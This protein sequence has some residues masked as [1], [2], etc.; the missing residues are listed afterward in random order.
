[1]S[2]L[3]ATPAIIQHVCAPIIYSSEHLLKTPL[4]DTARV[5]M[6]QVTGTDD[7][8]TQNATPSA[9]ITQR[10]YALNLQISFVVKTTHIRNTLSDARAEIRTMHDQHQRSWHEVNVMGWQS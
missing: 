10:A 7:G 6:H 1:M 9:I 4:T 8:Y 3:F 5:E 2:Y